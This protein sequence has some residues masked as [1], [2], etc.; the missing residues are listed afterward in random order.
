MIET[1]D[2]PCE[3]TIEPIA[4]TRPGDILMSRLVASLVPML[5]SSSGGDITLARGAAI[6]TVNAYRPRNHADLIAIA[7]IIAFG[8]AALSSLGFSMVDGLSLATTLRLRGNANALNR[9]AEQ[10]R[11]ALSQTPRVRGK[12]DCAGVP[13]TAAA[14]PAAAT[15]KT[16]MAS[17]VT[18]TPV[19]D[20]PVRQRQPDPANAAPTAAPGRIA[21]AATAASAVVSDQK[22]DKAWAS[23][24]T[25]VAGEF[26][27]SVPHLPPAERKHASMRAAILSSAANTLISGALPL[28]LRPGALDAMMSG[29]RI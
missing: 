15:G 12:S 23:A 6:E 13:G 11:R 25:H 22:W 24:M 29:P 10:N 3:P 7:Q 28:R 16:P 2:I 14:E 4:T 9:S 19:G 1:T 17:A 27:G 18:D 20:K 8:L 5:L 26:T 21:P